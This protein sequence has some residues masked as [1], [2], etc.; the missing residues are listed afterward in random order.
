MAKL[1]DRSGEVIGQR[2]ELIEVIGRGGQG[3]VYRASDR[4]MQRAVAVKVLGCEG[5]A[6]ARM[7]SN[8]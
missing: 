1:Q 6:R 3:T 8:D 5:R 2:Y 4:W 7:R